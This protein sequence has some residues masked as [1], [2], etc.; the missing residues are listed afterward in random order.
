M[1][2]QTSC[3][4]WGVCTRKQIIYCSTMAAKITTQT[5]LN[6]LQ[7]LFL[8]YKIWKGTN[9]T[10]TSD[11]SSMCTVVCHC[12]VQVSMKMFCR[13]PGSIIFMPYCCVCA[14]WSSPVVYVPVFLGRVGMDL[15]IVTFFP[16]IRETSVVSSLF[17]TK[18]FMCDYCLW[19]PCAYVSIRPSCQ[20]LKREFWAILVDKKPPV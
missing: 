5:F 9:K 18:G 6:L 12:V 2:N 10:S 4:H 1:H 11:Q 7:A 14:D 15:L 13:I 19:M 3:F 16:A 20:T 17:N 8:I